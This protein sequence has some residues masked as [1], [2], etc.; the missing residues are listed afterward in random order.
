MKPPP[1]VEPVDK[2]VQ[3][4]GKRN[5]AGDA[6]VKEV[7]QSSRGGTRGGRGGRRD[8]F[9]GNEQGMD[10]LSGFS[11]VVERYSARV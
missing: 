7:S 9:T 10:I 4:S 3:R 5:A 6:P 1:P 2:P 11:I 8:D